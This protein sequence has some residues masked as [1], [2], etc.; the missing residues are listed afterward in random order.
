MLA[1][2]QAIPAA[3]DPHA[4]V[5]TLLDAVPSGSYL[6]ISHPSSDFL[7]QETQQGIGDSWNGRVQQQFT[8]RGRDQVAQFFAGTDL[9]DPGLVLVEEWHPE[10]GTVVAAAAKSAMWGAVGRKR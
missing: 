6:A 1:I 4:I 7:D 3:D 8:F 2:L 5:A 9:I 10:P